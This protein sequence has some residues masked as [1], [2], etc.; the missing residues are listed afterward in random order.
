MILTPITGFSYVRYTGIV[1]GHIMGVN[2]FTDEQVEELRKNPY[3]ISV[4][5][6]Y[7]NYSE[8]FKELFLIDYQNGMPP[9]LIFQKYG[10]NPEVLGNRRRNT[11]TNRIK[12]QSERIEGFKDTR[13]GK[14][15]RPQTKDLTPEEEIARLKQ[16]NK[17]LEQENDFLKRVR[18][19][20]K[21][22]IFQASKTKPQNKNTN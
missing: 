22:Q 14:S 5:N 19:I 21:K 16:K 20:N 2:Y 15:G 9:Y 18:F 13:K 1:E 12:K 3:V 6:K 4:T 7:I 8:E 10:F 11:F 17:I